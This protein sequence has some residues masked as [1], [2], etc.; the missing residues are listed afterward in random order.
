MVVKWHWV[1]CKGQVKCLWGTC[2][3]DMTGQYVVAMIKGHSGQ[4]VKRKKPGCEMKGEELQRGSQSIALGFLWCGDST[5]Q[6]LLSSG[7][8]NDAPSEPMLLCSILIR[9]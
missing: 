6:F 8:Q 1:P 5:S 7:S 2:A 4:S 3:R 9:G